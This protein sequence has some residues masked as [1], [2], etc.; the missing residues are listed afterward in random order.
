MDIEK[1]I[2]AYCGEQNEKKKVNIRNWLAQINKMSNSIPLEESLRSK[3][4]L[5]RCFSTSKTNT[6]SRSQYQRIKELL[7]YVLNYYDIDKSIIPSR[8]EVIK[9]S[10]MSG[11]FGDLNSALS[12]VDEIGRHTIVGYNSSNGLVRIKSIVILSWLGF[13][14]EEIVN[15]VYSDI[16]FDKTAY[17]QKCNEKI[18]LPN[19]LF[20]ILSLQAESTDVMTFPRGRIYTYKIQ[21]EYLIKNR[22]GERMLVDHLHHLFK[23]FN[24]VA[25]SSSV[26]SFKGLKISSLFVR[27]YEDRSSED[28][29][30]KIQKH[31]QC[32]KRVSYGYK[33]L[34]LQWLKKFHNEEI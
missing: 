33:R 27:I 16:K 18:E 3:H 17:I 10:Q 24:E 19:E 23:Q 5:L 32:D 6:V 29:Y 12:F 26:L 25:N 20:R 9:S 14:P 28:I 2:D 7:L 11:F 30:T 22:S 34:Y 4:F 31:A 13:S 15:L 1:I 8:D 21:T